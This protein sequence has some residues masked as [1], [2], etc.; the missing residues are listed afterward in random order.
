VG[1]PGHL[2][3]AVSTRENNDRLLEA[4]DRAAS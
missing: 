2:R 4:W 1:F 3:I